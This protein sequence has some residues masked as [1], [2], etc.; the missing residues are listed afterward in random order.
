MIPV[1]FWYFSLGGSLA[2]LA[3]AI[4]R[5]DPDTLAPGREDYQAV[6]FDTLRVLHPKRAKTLAFAKWKDKDGDEYLFPDSELRSAYGRGLQS[7]H[8]PGLPGLDDAVRSRPRRPGP[9]GLLHLQRADGRRPLPQHAR[10][11]EL[12]ADVH[13]PRRSVS[14]ALLLRHRLR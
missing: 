4:H 8:E 12:S 14:N 13:V 3:Y 5:L 6:L 7:R 11:R 1:A 9:V 2:L 10:D